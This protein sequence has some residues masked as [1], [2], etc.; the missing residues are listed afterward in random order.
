MSAKGIIIILFL[1]QGD[2]V[3]P[4]QSSSCHKQNDRLEKYLYYIY[5]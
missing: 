5:I 1:L 2:I 3:W 4:M